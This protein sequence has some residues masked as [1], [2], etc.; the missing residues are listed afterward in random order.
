MNAVARTQVH[1]WRGAQLATHVRSQMRARSPCIDALLRMHV[2]EWRGAQLAVHVLSQVSVRAL[3][4]GAP[5][6]Y[7]VHEWR[8]AQ[9]VLNVCSE[10]KL[11]VPCINAVARARTSASGEGLHSCCI[12]SRTCKSAYRA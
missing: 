7:H 3:Y 1:E 10:V 8:G 4:M 6:R 2:G 5:V 12:W 9:L 11:V